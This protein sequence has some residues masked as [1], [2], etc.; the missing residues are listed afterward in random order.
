MKR[1]IILAGH[2]GSG[3][4]TASNFLRETNQL[5]YLALG[6]YI[7]EFLREKKIPLNPATKAEYSAKLLQESKNGSIVDYLLPAIES[8][9]DYFLLDSAVD[10]HDVEVLKQY[11]PESCLL[12]IDSPIEIRVRNII[13]RKRPDDHI[14][15]DLIIQ[16]AEKQNDRQLVLKESADIVVMNNASLEKYKRELLQAY[17]YDTSSFRR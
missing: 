14:T 17:E 13:S 9:E 6:G 7:D 10:I 11:H 1:G 3:K 5:N 15:L 16:D 4:S 12:Y 8:S 2:K